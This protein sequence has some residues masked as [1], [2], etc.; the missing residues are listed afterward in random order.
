[1]TTPYISTA[2]TREEVD[3]TK[4]PSILQFGTDW[5]GYCQAA[6][7]LVEEALAGAPDVAH[8]KIEDGPGRKLGRSYRVKLWPTLIFLKD[9]VEA[10]RVVRPEGIDEIRAALAKIV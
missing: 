6:E 4:G 9:G 5:C 1:M 2:P 7:P 10:A 8:T 3:A